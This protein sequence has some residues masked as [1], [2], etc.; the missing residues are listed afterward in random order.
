MRVLKSMFL[1]TSNN[2]S[3]VLPVLSRHIDSWTLNKIHKDHII[4]RSSKY[5]F[6][7]KFFISCL[8][9]LFLA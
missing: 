3:K 7:A 9:G 4:Y 8:Y 2:L 5:L 6:N 1:M